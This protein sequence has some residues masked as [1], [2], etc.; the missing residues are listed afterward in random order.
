MI[1]YLANTDDSDY[2]DLAKDLVISASEYVH[3][4]N[5]L[6]ISIIVDKYTEDSTE[7]RESIEKLDKQRSIAHNAL[8][9]KVKIVNRICRAHE[10]PIIFVGNEEARI[11]IA[12]FAHELVAEFFNNRRL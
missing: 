4:V 2:L 8:I 9:T 3:S 1:K 12:D 6:E 5:A 7:Y 10:I 11:E